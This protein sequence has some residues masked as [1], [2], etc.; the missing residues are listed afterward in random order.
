MSASGCLNPKAMRVSRRILVL[1]DSINAFDRPES[2]LA[3][4]AS[5]SAR[6]VRPSLTN[7]G[8]RQRGPGQP[9]IEGVFT[10]VTRDSEDTTESFFE[11]VSTIEPPESSRTV[12][13]T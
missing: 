9:V 1:V 7:S 11:Q 5:S 12:A 4:I 2:R 13:P 6:M 8:M 3:W 10:V